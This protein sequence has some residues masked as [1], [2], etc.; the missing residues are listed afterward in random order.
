M[1]LHG[2]DGISEKIDCFLEKYGVYCI[3]FGQDGIIGCL[4]IRLL[5]IVL[6]HFL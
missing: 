5:Y 2:F 3:L 4:Y 6:P 1:L